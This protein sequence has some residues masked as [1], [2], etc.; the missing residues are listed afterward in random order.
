MVAVPK[1]E[2]GR[3]RFNP[4]VTDDVL[5]VL[6]SID[7]YK[8]LPSFQGSLVEAVMRWLD[9][10]GRD[11]YFRDVFDLLT[12]PFLF[13]DIDEAERALERSLALNTKQTIHTP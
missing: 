4:S 5:N 13:Y 12:S 3:A 1:F 9:A 11:F 10:I 2:P 7:G 6:P 8:P